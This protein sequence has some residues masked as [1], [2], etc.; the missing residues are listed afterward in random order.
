MDESKRK[1]QVSENQGGFKKEIGVFGG[2]SIIGGI[3][4]GSGI[5][6]IGSI[7][8]QRT[9]MSLGA[10]L[11]CWIIGGVVS[12]LG[13]M[14]FAELGASDPLAGGKTIYLSKAFHPFMGFADGFCSWLVSNPAS[15]AGVAI[16]LPTAL[17]SFFDISNFAIKVIAIALIVLLSIFNCFGVKQGS[18]FQN[19]TMVAKVV[20]LFIIIIGALIFGRETP[21]LSLAITG[22]GGETLG[23]GSM[24][25]MI[26]F[27]VVASLWAYEG[28]VNLNLVAEEIKNPKRNL[29]LAIIIAIGGITLLYTLFNYSIYRMIPYD[30]IVTRINAGD[31]YLG[32][33]VVNR[34][35]GTFAGAFVTLAMVLAML[36]C[37]NGMIMAF[38]RTYYAMGRSGHFF[39]SQGTLHPKYG[40]PVVAIF[41]QAVV[42]IILVI[43]QSLSQLTAMVVF[44][45][46]MFNLA[47]VIAVLRYRKLFPDMKRPYK[48]PG[49]AVTVAITSLLFTALAI[50][51]LLED[52]VSAIIGFGALA[53]SG[54]LYYVFGKRNQKQE[55][56]AKS[57]SAK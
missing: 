2:V 22:A 27:A 48:V 10:A 44:V 54:V 24:L 17:L 4:I 3:M 56:T 28:W 51:S 55:E 18:I 26:G 47:T 32:T 42:A 35:M 15:I 11:L 8:L 30:E 21:D 31:L 6:Y 41:W 53:I 25:G 19:I 46:I 37:L 33:E 5:F 14:C 20:P 12:L 52:P 38:P 9:N 7:V 34:L 36:N 16:A 43:F 23:I 29:P 40:T 13:G 45:G 49:G 50:N 1:V 57:N 39:K